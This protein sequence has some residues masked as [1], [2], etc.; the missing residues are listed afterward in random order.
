MNCNLTEILRENGPAKDEL[1]LATTRMG[2]LLR[3][4]DE[5]NSPQRVAKTQHEKHDGST[6]HRNT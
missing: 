2:E 5:L 3:A 1:Q 6:W 4:K